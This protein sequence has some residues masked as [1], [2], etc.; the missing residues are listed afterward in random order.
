MQKSLLL[1]AFLILSG[2]ASAD[3]FRC[4]RSIVKVGDSSNKLLKKCGDP[5]R[6]YSSKAFVNNN[7]RQVR[8]S[9]SNWVYARKGGKD[10]IVAVYSGVVVKLKID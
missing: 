6:K 1:A 2:N 3:S 10:M 9:V 8:A 4:G 7:G 5:V